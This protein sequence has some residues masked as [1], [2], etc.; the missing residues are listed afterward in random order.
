MWDAASALR[1]CLRNSSR[2]PQFG[3]QLA[4]S[5]RRLA[6]FPNFSSNESSYSV[7]MIMVRLHDC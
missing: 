6:S 2:S 7:W 4:S 1:A 3:N 5:I